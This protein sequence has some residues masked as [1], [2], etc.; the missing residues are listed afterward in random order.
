[1]RVDGSLQKKKEKN[2]KSARTHPA[3][4]QIWDTLLHKVATIQRDGS[5]VIF[6]SDFLFAAGQFSPLEAPNS[7]FWLCSVRRKLCSPAT[8]LP[9]PQ[10]HS[11]IIANF[12]PQGSFLMKKLFNKIGKG[13]GFRF[14]LWFLLVRTEF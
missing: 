4:W 13:R 10:G 7:Q 11:I 12:I 9:K 1:M 5:F 6:N 2:N 14:S 3:N 8:T